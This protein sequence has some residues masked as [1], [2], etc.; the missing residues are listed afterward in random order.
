MFISFVVFKY[1]QRYG[2]YLNGEH[3]LRFFFDYFTQTITLEPMLGTYTM[4]L[5][6]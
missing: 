6:L 4:I 2:F 3:F 5:V 1:L